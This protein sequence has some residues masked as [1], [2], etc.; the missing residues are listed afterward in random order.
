MTRRATTFAAAITTMTNA[1]PM[2]QL[3][4]IHTLPPL[5]DCCAAKRRRSES[6]RRIEV[7]QTSALPLGY[8]ARRVSN[9]TW[10]FEFLNP[11]RGHD[12][13]AGCAHSNVN[14]RQTGSMLRSMRRSGTNQMSATST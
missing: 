10:E 14:Q 11:H 7:L 1:V 5:R 13:D 9:F 2:A 6:N 4:I 3:G 12:L 8:G